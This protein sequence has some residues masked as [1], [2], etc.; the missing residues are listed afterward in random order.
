[1]SVG[2]DSTTTSTDGSTPG[3]RSANGYGPA[4]L[5][6]GLDDC[7]F[8]SAKLNYIKS[9][10]TLIKDIVSSDTLADKSTDSEMLIEGIANIE[11]NIKDYYD[12]LIS[13]PRYLA[14][15]INQLKE[16]FSNLKFT[17]LEQYTKDKFLSYIFDSRFISV[18]DLNNKTQEIRKFKQILNEKKNKRDSLILEVDQILRKN[19]SRHKHIV[20]TN[21]ANK[22]IAEQNS[23]LA[24]RIDTLSQ[25]LLVLGS[26]SSGNSHALRFKRKLGELDDCSNEVASYLASLA[27]S[28]GSEGSGEGDVNHLDIVKKLDY[29]GTSSDINEF[30]LFNSKLVL[31]R[32]IKKRKSSASSLEM[33]HSSEHTHRY[34]LLRTTLSELSA[35]ERSL[36]AKKKHLD[37]SIEQAN[38]Q[39]VKGAQASQTSSTIIN[40]KN[41]EVLS[42]Y[43][44]SELKLMEI[45][46]HSSN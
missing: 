21:E 39:S 9:L 31:G 2:F 6:P 30:L 36:L 43:V 23:R 19:D 41:R 40:G 34:N 18:E 12:K 46:C 14:H 4:T 42:E 7:E 20:S 45:L 5:V 22:T 29:K 44:S 37:E 27:D 35:L 24:A 1:M 10:N 17:Y 26:G 13:E 15:V 32:I 38:S 28:E 8:S 16:F 11:D 25:Q 33:K 3:P